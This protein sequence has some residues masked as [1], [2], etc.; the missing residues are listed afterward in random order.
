MKKIAV[1]FGLLVGFSCTQPKDNISPT[2]QLISNVSIVDVQTG[3]I[4]ENRQ[5]VVDSGIIVHITDIV[6]NAKSY[7]LQIDG[8]GKY[9]V[10]GLAEMHAHIPPPSTD[11]QRIEETLFLYLSNGITTIRGMLGDPAH[12]ILREKAKNG[13]I[14]SPRIFT[15]SPSLNGNTVT[16]K[17]EA[18]EKVTAYQKEG[19]DFLKI[20]PGVPLEA[21]D[22]M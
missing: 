6:E 4:W 13:E 21:F 19:Y 9:L 18:I 14:L 15:S 12:L 7:P 1:L 11:P 22:Q 3:T 10:P 2:A 16:S 5:V 20:H 8:K 17:T